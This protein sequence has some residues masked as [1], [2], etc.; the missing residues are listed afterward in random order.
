M[1]INFCIILGLTFLLGS[2]KTSKN[3]DQNLAV[4]ITIDGYKYKVIPSPDG[5]DSKVG[6]IDCGDV[7]FDYDY[8]K[9]SNSGPITPIEEFRRMFDTYHHIKFFEMKMIDPKVNKLFLDSVKIID[10]R[11]KLEDDTLLFECEPCNATAVFTF[12]KQ[13]NYYP[14]TLSKKAIEMT[15]YEADL[16]VEDGFVYKVYQK[17]GER[18][19]LYIQPE[20]NRFKKKDCLSVTV[21]KSNLSDSE[22]KEILHS[23]KIKN[24]QNASF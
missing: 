5:I 8:G 13:T 15:G 20:F 21:N 6:T 17:E 11:E 12:K 22:I 18:P 7:Q 19:G 2:C 16:K 10:V 3:I 24:Y 14:F 4:P 1:R 23:L 9:Y